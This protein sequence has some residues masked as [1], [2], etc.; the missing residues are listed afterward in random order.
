LSGVLTLN[1]LLL[2][3]GSWR[4]STTSSGAASSWGGTTTGANVGQEVLDILALKSLFTRVS[5]QFLLRERPQIICTLAKRLVQIGSTSA[6][7]AAVIKV[8]NFSAFPNC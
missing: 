2:S 1:L 6:T 8:C 4:I 7:L 3:S 5:A